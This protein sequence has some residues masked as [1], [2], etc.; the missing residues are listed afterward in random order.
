MEWT[1]SLQNY[2]K[3]RNLVQSYSFIFQSNHRTPNVVH[4]LIIP[5]QNPLQLALPSQYFVSIQSKSLPDQWSNPPN[6][7][8]IHRL[9]TIDLATVAAKLSG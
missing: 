8:L 5:V 1:P 2:P 9:Y 6:P 3:S 7:N 4:P